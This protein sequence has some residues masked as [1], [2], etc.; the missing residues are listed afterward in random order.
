MY[1]VSDEHFGTLALDVE[2]AGPAHGAAVNP[3]SRSYPIVPT[4]GENGDWTLDTTGMDPCG[5]VVR[6]RTWDRTIV[7][8][9][10]GWYCEDFV[11]FCL[12]AATS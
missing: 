6:L 1:S 11:G 4:L 3:P 10:G 2:P 8:S 7:S 9:N 5:Y 12:K